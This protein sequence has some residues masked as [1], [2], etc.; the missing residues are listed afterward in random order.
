ME[1]QK[2]FV[3]I[4]GVET[5]YETAGEG[6]PLLLIH[7][8]DSDS[9][10]WDKQFYDFASHFKTIRF[11]LRGFGKTP[12]PAGEFQILDDIKGLLQSLNI[13]SAHIMGYSYGGT[14]SPS[15]AIKYP[16][17]VKSL[18]LVSPGMIG[19]QWSNE[20]STYFKVFQEAYK[21]GNQ[22]EIMRLLK[23]K[24][25][26]GPHRDQSGLDEVCELLD[27]MFSHAMNEVVREG[28]P[29]SPGDTRSSLHKISVPTLIVVGEIDFDDYHNIAQYYEQE[30]TNS[31]KIVIPNAAHFLNL[32]EPDLLNEY[33]IR[34]IQG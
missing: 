29:L 20:V 32:E 17:M 8:V 4:D 3:T 10:M 25:V 11:D 24:S 23:W 6:E 34:F 22:Q 12:M 28:K 30:I 5:Y 13:E 21:Q 16:D 1:I 14:I 7:G 2:G 18:I 33:V 19:H 27:K 15:F 26:Y 9:R 31:R